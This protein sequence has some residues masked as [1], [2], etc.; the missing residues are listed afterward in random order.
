[1]GTAELGWSQT[2]VGAAFRLE[3][4]TKRRPTTTTT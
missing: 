3:N 1:V 2:R 4:H